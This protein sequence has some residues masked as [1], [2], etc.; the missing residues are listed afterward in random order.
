MENLKAFE[1]DKTKS[2]NTYFRVHLETKN[3][4]YFF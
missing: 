2:I 4:T 1:A 3:I